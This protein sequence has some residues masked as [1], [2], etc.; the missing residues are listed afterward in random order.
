[1][2]FYD[3]GVYLAASIHL[4][5]GVLPYRD[6][7]FVNPPGILL[8][9]Y[10]V[11][12]FSRVFGSHDGFILARV[13]TSLVTALNASLLAWLVR[14]R[15]RIAML[16]AGIGLA[17]L[18]ITFFVS[19]SLKLDPYCV[20]FVLLGSSVLV[21]RRQD[22]DRLSAR[23]FAVGGVLFGLAAVIKIWAFFP[24][25]ALLICLAPRHRR[26]ILVFVGAAAGGFVVPS[27]PFLVYAPRS[28]FSQVFTVQL[29]QRVNPAVSPGVL[30]RLTALTGFSPASI[31]PTGKEAAAAFLVLICII[32]AAFSHRV[33]DE[34]GDLFL[35]VAA[36]ITMCGLLVAPV[37]APYYGYFA[38][39]FLIGT[40]AVSVARLGPLFRSPLKRARV[41]RGIRRMAIWASGLAGV[42]LVVALTLYATTFY[43]NYA[44]TMG[45]SG[46]TLSTIDSAIPAGSCV[47]YNYVF[48]GI[49]TNRFISDHPDCPNVV[50][51]YGMWQEWGNHTISPKPPFTAKWKRYFESAQY[52]VLNSPRSQLIPWT[53]SLAEW[54]RNN[55]RLVLKRFNLFI[56]E[57]N[58]ST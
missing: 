38:A 50:D 31:A 4:S 53:P 34:A 7:T 24:F 55:Y 25:L 49:D 39:P 20:F 6:F 57:R 51:A 26:R 43:R 2:S 11:A 32:A 37:S 45:I 19:S 42:V 14:F 12:V 36:V 15:G 58:V 35:L 41:G 10:P 28:F 54:F 47:V 8:L 23:S 17:L 56:Y 18:P 3:S 44:S 33:E 13:V 27:L 22:L 40:F 9:M 16:I 52:V 5:S 29:F 46:P 30:W 48:Y 1:M 21:S